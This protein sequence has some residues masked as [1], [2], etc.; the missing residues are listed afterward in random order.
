MANKKT[1]SKVTG[2][3]LFL[4]TEKIEAVLKSFS[5]LAKVYFANLHSPFL[6]GERVS[7]NEIHPSKRGTH[8]F[9]KGE[10]S[11]RLK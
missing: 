6:K 8:S 9:H 2:N 4:S 1:F 11:R 10:S 7:E 5:F 3:N